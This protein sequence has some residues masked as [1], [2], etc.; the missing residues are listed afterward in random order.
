MHRQHWTQRAPKLRMC[1]VCLVQATPQHRATQV[2]V[3]DGRYLNDSHHCTGIACAG[4]SASDTRRMALRCS[5]AGVC[6]YG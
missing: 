1:D 5:S 4:V 2:P 6:T 3:A